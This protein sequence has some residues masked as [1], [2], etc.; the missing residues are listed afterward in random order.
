MLSA[1]E[2]ARTDVKTVEAERGEE[3]NTSGRA[4]ECFFLRY[5]YVL[6]RIEPCRQ[7]EPAARSCAFPEWKTHVQAARGRRQDLD[8]ITDAA[9]ILRIVHDV[10]EGL[11]V[12]GH[13]ECGLVIEC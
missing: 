11:W 5:G 9:T 12:W 10:V 13:G 7:D 6:W 2:R 1:D 4:R 3:G 8:S